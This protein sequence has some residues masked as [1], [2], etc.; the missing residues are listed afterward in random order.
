MTTAHRGEPGGRRPRWFAIPY[1]LPEGLEWLRNY[2]FG[3]AG[4]FAGRT[5]FLPNDV[6]LNRIERRMT[7]AFIGD[8]L[9]TGHARLTFGDGL[10]A[11]F[12]DADCLVANFEGTISDAPRVFMGQAHTPAVI[13]ALARLFPPERTILALANNH[14][15]DFAPDEFEASCARLADAGFTLIGRRDAPATLI[16]GRVNL[17]SVTRWSNQPCD[18]IARLGDADAACHEGASMNVLYPH[19]G[20]EH[21]LYPTP[22]GIRQAR[23]L[24]ARWGLVVGHHSHC[25]Q[26]VTAYATDGG[27]KAVA[28][29]L[30]DFSVLNRKTRFRWGIVLKAAVGPDAAGVW[31]TGRLRWRF[32]KVHMPR[33]SER[34]ITLMDACSY[35]DR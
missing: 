5:S 26:P 33:E 29:S 24:L 7:L 34:R 9:P 3:P 23:R 32:T 4:N 25:P 16:G 8:V 1:N 10:L 19:W 2:F 28:Y 13:D 35:F 31:R 12:R 14:A 17:A 15:G 20:Y 21:Q 11:F 27:R 30:G 18:W 6:T 22:E